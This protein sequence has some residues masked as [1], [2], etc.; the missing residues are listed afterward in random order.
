MSRSYKHNPGYCCY[1]STGHHLK[2]YATRR[3]RRTALDTIGYLS[4]PERDPLISQSKRR[5]T[6]LYDSWEIHDGEYLKFRIYEERKY[7]RIV[8]GPKDPYSFDWASVPYGRYMYYFWARDCY[9]K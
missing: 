1:T 4:E 7:D 3:E 2:H 9:W 6:R 8:K 5:F